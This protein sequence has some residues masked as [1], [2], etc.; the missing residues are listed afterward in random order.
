M[1]GARGQLVRAA[2]VGLALLLELAWL[3]AWSD[4]AGAWLAGGGRGPALP[5]SILAGVLMG[6]WLL[7]TALLRRGPPLGVARTLLTVVTLGAMAG[8]GLW[9][10]WMAEPRALQR[11]DWALLGESG[12]SLRAVA[13]AALALGACWRGIALARRAQTMERAVARFQLGAVALGALLLLSLPSPLRDPLPLGTLTGAVLLA[14]FAGLISLP[15]ARVMELSESPRHAGAPPLQL[16][17]PWLAILGGT[18]AALMLGALVLASVLTPDL[19]WH[20]LAPLGPVLEVVVKALVYAIGIPLGLLIQGL[21]ALFRALGRGQE[22]TSPA[23]APT[24]DWIEALRAA[25]QPGQAVPGWVTLAAE[26]LLGA[27]LIALIALLVTRAAA[28]LADWWQGD[29]VEE[30]RDFVGPHVDPA[31]LLRQLAALWPRRRPRAQRA[32]A[33][34][35]EPDGTAWRVRRLYRAFLRLAAQAGRA[36]APAE[37]PLEFERALARVPPFAAHR[38]EV[39]ILTAAYEQARYAP[40][41][42]AEDVVQAAEQAVRRLQGEVE[43]ALRSFPQ[44]AR[45]AEQ[46]VRRRQGE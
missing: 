3:F 46:A 2:Q 39:E 13:A 23:P 12:A 8:A 43:A 36:R 31:E 20:L 25:Q 10:A 45:A 26:A 14:L 29:D 1:V 35:S 32:G 42:P 6:M 15:L 24:P 21:I 22:P 37:T 27:L 30:A 28:R 18:V 16:T 38:G 34:P 33:L 17:G 40:D 41:P 19:L 4:A 9:A 7:A 44:G 5:L 11:L